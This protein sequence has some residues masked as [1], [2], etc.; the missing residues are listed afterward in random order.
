MCPGSGRKYDDYRDPGYELEDS[1]DY[2]PAQGDEEAEPALASFE[3][4]RKDSEA[5]GAAGEVMDRCLKLLE[6]QRLETQKQLARAEEA[7][8]SKDWV[9]DV[10]TG[11]LSMDEFEVWECPEPYKYAT[12]SMM[13][14][15]LQKQP[16]EETR[17]SV[18]LRG[19]RHPCISTVEP[20][21]VP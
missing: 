7:E 13:V 21:I 5:S 3:D 12:C 8:M 20:Y 16:E 15:Y 19:S 1:A 17:S 11:I 6:R 4:V 18:Y 14:Q 10:L 2:Q 9:N